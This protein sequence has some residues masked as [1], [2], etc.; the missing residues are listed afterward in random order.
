MKHRWQLKV[1]YF[2][3]GR[4]G[5]ANVGNHNDTTDTTKGENGSDRGLG[6]FYL[7][8]CIFVVFVVSWW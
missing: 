8:L 3:A 2:R 6:R 4:D 1:N 5:R 7:H